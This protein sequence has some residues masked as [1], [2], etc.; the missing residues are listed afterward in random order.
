MK[1]ILHTTIEDHYQP[2]D[3]IRFKFVDVYERWTFRYDT[4]TSEC[5][6]ISYNRQVVRGYDDIHTL[7]WWHKLK[8]WEEPPY[9][10]E[11]FQR[12]MDRFHTAL[13]SDDVY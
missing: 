13:E 9:D 5:T 4:K 2:F 7:V 8:F 12:A 6:L 11:V 1:R 3:H 10:A